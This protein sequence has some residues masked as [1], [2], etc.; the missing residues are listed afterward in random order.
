MRNSVSCYIFFGFDSCSFCSR[1]L[2]TCSSWFATFLNKCRFAWIKLVGPFLTDAWMIM[3]CWWFCLFFTHST[4]DPFVC[5]EYIESSENG[6]FR[7]IVIIVMLCLRVCTGMC[8]AQ[9]AP[10]QS[11][12]RS[13]V[14]HLSSI[15]FVYVL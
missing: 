3:Q 7:I 4:F 8:M 1:L 11:I 14:V 12:M 6:L 9:S 2:Y 5:G 13:S 10:K 15:W